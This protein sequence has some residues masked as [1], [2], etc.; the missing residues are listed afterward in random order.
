MTNAKDQKT[1]CP[2]DRAEKEETEKSVRMAE[3]D[4]R[5]LL[6]ILLQAGYREKQIEQWL[7]DDGR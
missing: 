1:H 2:A 3:T 6:T 7:Q 5:A 4:M